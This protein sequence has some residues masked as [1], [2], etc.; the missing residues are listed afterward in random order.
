MRTVVREVPAPT[1]LGNAVIRIPPGAPI[2]LELRLESVVEGVLVSGS[3][4]AQATGECVRC[5]EPVDQPIEVAL[6]Q[7]YD[8]PDLRFSGDASEDEEFTHQIEDERIDLEPV[9]RDLAVL[10]LPLKPLCRD[11]CPGLCPTCGVRLADDPEH[12]HDDVDPRWADLMVMMDPPLHPASQ[13]ES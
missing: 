3:A 8:Y 10:A 7:L 9:L 2:Q 11:D 1:D 13:E 4:R 5:L 6:Q 12:D